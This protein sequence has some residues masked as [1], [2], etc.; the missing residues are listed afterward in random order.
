LFV[1]HLKDMTG[2]LEEALHST[3]AWPSFSFGR[4]RTLHSGG[5]VKLLRKDKN[6]KHSADSIHSTDLDAQIKM[7]SWL[8]LL[9]WVALKAR[10]RRSK[11]DRKKKPHGSQFCSFSFSVALLASNLIKLS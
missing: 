4:R 3:F 1:I 6:K 7:K 10:K 8:F 5:S 9:L 2:G 11:G